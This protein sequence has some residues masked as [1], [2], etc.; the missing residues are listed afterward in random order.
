MMYLKKVL[1]LHTLSIVAFVCR[2][3]QDID[4]VQYII[5]T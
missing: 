3:K 4:I 2:P 1:P 5:N